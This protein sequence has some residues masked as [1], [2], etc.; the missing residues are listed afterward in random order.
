SKFLKFSP[1]SPSTSSS[2]Q[3]QL[4]FRRCGDPVSLVCCP[5]LASRPGSDAPHVL[6]E[7]PEQPEQ[8]I[9]VV[10]V[11]FVSDLLTV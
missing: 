2:P 1:Y 11:E 5:I 7:K 4:L 3:P 6:D 9:I 8:E 10:F